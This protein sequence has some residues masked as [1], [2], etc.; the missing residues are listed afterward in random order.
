MPLNL[1][2]IAYYFDYKYDKAMFIKDSFSSIYLFIPALVLVFL[3]NL[4]FVY[5]VCLIA[6]EIILVFALKGFYKTS[7]G[8]I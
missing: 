3:L 1:I 2:F 5:D 8:K 4:T 6:I 7:H